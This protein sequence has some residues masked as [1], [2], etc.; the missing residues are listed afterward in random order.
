M[1]REVK[2]KKVLLLCGVELDKAPYVLPYIDLLKQNAVPF[3]VLCRKTQ[4][5][6]DVAGDNVIEYDK[7]YDN[8]APAWKKFI[9]M[10]EQARKAK[11]LIKKNGYSRVILF[12]AQKGIF[13][14][15]FMKKK[16][17]GQY[18]LDIR[19]Y[20][21][22]LRIPLCD[23]ILKSVIEKSA[24]TVISSAGFKKWLP[25]S[26]KYL[27]C[28]NT[29]FEMIE[30]GFFNNT[31]N[32]FGGINDSSQV[33]KLLTIGQIRDSHANATVIDAIQSNN[34]IELY[35]VGSGNGVPSL[36]QHCKV[37]NSERVNFLGRYKKDEE[38]SIVEGYDMINSYMDHD[39]NS[40]SLL[41]NRL[42]LSAILRKPILVRGGT[43]QAELVSR[44]G[45]GIVVD[46]A[47]NLAE[48][49]VQYYDAIDWSRYDSDCK[50]FLNEVK[51]ENTQWATS[52]LTFAN[53]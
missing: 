6:V 2:E 50:C 17:P 8:S 32:K 38:S 28:H 23:K 12:T 46:D 27:V 22:I 42:Y 7:E 48:A 5:A 37:N 3:D 14:S 15:R 13:L 20:T 4:M 29:S 9:M 11:R 40:D 39:I 25:D 31:E 35:F 41:T 44:Y 26:D 43:Y 10:I 34:G 24:Y 16:F 51:A 49:I 36:Q 21:P 19:D 52:M 30:Y 53:N 45:L 33:I 47:E 1:K 18:V